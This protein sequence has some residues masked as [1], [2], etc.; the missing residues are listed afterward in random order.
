VGYCCWV[1][2]CEGNIIAYGVI[3]VAMGECH[4]LNLCVKPEYQNN[5]WGQ[6]MLQHLLEIACA[7]GAKIAFLEVRPSNEHAYNLYTNAG[8]NEVGM[9]R[10]YYP[11]EF[12]REDAKILACTLIS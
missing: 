3:S 10:D 1:L 6:S 7:H 8:F 11:A 2:E 4:I 12:G 5:G 9:R